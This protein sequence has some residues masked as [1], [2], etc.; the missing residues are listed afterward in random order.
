MDRFLGVKEY[1]SDILYDQRQHAYPLQYQL[2]QP[3]N[4]NDIQ[5]HI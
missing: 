4:K 1:E 5:I 3:K 2:E